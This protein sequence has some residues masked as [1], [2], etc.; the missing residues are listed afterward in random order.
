MWK[1]LIVSHSAFYTVKPNVGRT[2]ISSKRINP[3]LFHKV[4]A[5][6][7]L[8]QWQCIL[9]YCSTAESDP[10]ETIKLNSSWTNGV[11]CLISALHCSQSY[12]AHSVVHV[13]GMTQ[14]FFLC[15]DWNL[16]DRKETFEVVRLMCEHQ[17]GLALLV[18]VG[19]HDQ[20]DCA[21]SIVWSR[22]SRSA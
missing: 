19:L 11:V 16:A 9:A 8:K 4:L 14:S 22:A 6:F 17:F 7:S 2:C 5:S 13:E 12:A 3:T 18:K 20:I 15:K 21:W 10:Q 1:G